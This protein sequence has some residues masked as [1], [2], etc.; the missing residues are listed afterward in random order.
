MKRIVTNAGL[1]KIFFALLLVITVMFASNYIVYRNSISGIYDKITENNTLVVRSVIQSFDNS[2]R[3]VNNLIYSIH[4]LPYD[5]AV[6]A[7]GS[8]NMSKVYMLRD[9]ISQLS[10][11]VD[12]I[13]DVIVFYDDSNLAITARGTSDLHTLFSRK[14]RHD[15]YNADYWR[16]FSLTKQSLKTFPAADFR[17]YADGTQFKTK[18]LMAIFGGNKIRMSAK[19]IIVLVNVE[20]LMK[21]VDRKA[22]LPG[23][24]LIVLDEDRNIILSTDENWGLM[25]VLNDVYFNAS[26]ETSVTR[27]DYE[28][29]FYKSSF[30]SFIYIDKVPYQFQNIDSVNRAN[31]LIMLSA[32]VCAVLLSGLLSAYLYK[33]VQ[34]ILRLFGEGYVK[35]NDFLNI[36]SGIL[37]MQMENESYR[38]RLR[39]ADAE[40]RK[41][42]LF[43]ALDGSVRAE[44]RDEGMKAHYPE[45]FARSHFLLACVQVVP[46]EEG[47]AGGAWAIGERIR[48]AAGGDLTSVD[49]F[50]QGG[51][52]YLL[53]FGVDQPAGRET[54]LRRLRNGL[55]RVEK[56]L[57]GCSLWG[58]AG[59]MYEAQT[60]NCARAYE[61]IMQAMPYRKVKDTPL[62]D[63]EALR[64]EWNVYFPFEKVEKLSNLLLNARA[65]EAAAIVRDTL[66]ENV[67]RN[68]H[69]NQLRHVANAMLYSMLQA[70]ES[71]GADSQT[72]YRMETEFRRTADGAADV[73]AVEEALAKLAAETAAHGRG[74]QRSKL[75]PAFISQYIDLHYMENLYLDHMA[76]VLETTPKYFSNYFKKTFGV[77]YVEYLNKVRLQHA[78]VLLRD[79]SLS[80]AEVGEKTGYIN[81]S[82]FTTT[83]KKYFGISPS[84][85]RKRMVS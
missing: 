39:L 41:A 59:K 28:Y 40:L 47:A 19:N 45:F 68:V 4:G 3:S 83:F 17:V 33:P 48:E 71:A 58:C 78:K 21:H 27:E 5:D 84:E 56:G 72:L 79:T 77:N 11:N 15:L 57:D 61:E 23:A 63:A 85:Y 80:V 75:N 2:F 42:A 38:A 29:N 35:G 67:E 36:H 22:M 43:Q 51:L 81:S 13:E 16:S 73:G 64:Y 49:V 44:E 1:L 37:R 82:T 69:R 52:R 20:A 50:H 18:K 74:E 55:S 26:N 34:R 46:T 10:S 60:S 14:Y 53:V 66:R 31:L 32:I 62:L 54:L 8:L 76:E 24:S 65:D 12:F 9:H 30:N 6:Q 70:L 7:D 25:E